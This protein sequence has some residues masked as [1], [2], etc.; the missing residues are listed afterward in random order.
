MSLKPII[1]DLDIHIR[2]INVLFSKAC[3][4]SLDDDTIEEDG[5]AIDLDTVLNFYNEGILF[6]TRRFLILSEDM[7]DEY[8]KMCVQRG[9][10]SKGLK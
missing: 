3:K 1:Q 10:D 9:D 8:I 6:F 5:E 4:V 2:E 7:R